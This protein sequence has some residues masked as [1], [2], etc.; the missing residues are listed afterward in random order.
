MK[1]LFISPNAQR[2]FMP[3]LPLGLALVAV[4]V[5]G[6]MAVRAAELPIKDGQK[7]AFMGDSITEAGAGAPTGYVNLV[8]RGLEANG[9]KATA[10][11]AGMSGH[12][13]T[14][15]FRRL[16]R[17][18][19]S[20][21]ADWM[22]L[23]C[24]VNDIGFRDKG[25]PL[26]LF[27]ESVTKIIDQCQ[28]AGVRVMILTAT[29]T[30]EDQPNPTNQKLIAYNEILRTLAKERNCLLA[31]LNADMQAAI[32]KAGV[33]KKGRVLTS[34]GVHMNP[35]GNQMMATGVLKAFGLSAEQIEKS[36][37]SWTDAAPAAAPGSKAK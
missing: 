1:S 3:T 18:V 37:K 27:K 32:A 8:I 31:D 14:Q 11:P 24:G 19:L 7:I 2:L 5:L 17:D 26:A 34:D 9:I 33:E 16:D 28:A 25:V 6:T 12:R 22:T 21:K 4:V 10:I 23:S 13:A 35:A 15:M 20:K 36:Q 29:M 30:G